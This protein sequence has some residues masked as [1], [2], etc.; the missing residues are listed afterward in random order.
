M[1]VLLLGGDHILLVV[2]GGR[3]ELHWLSSVEVMDLRRGVVWSW[4][5]LTVPRHEAALAVVPGRALPDPRILQL[6]VV[7]GW[8]GRH[9]L[10]TVEC[11]SL[12]PLTWTNLILN[13]NNR[14][15]SINNSTPRAATTRAPSQQDAEDAEEEEEQNTLEITRV[16]CLMHDKEEK[17]LDPNH[18]KTT[19]PNGQIRRRRQQVDRLCHTLL[20]YY[21]YQKQ[22]GLNAATA[23]LSRHNNQKRDQTTSFQKP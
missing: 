9:E 5:D 20:F 6:W 11:L 3:R 2:A 12:V 21:L 19:V 17:F 14:N 4:P 13:N 22:H 23:L 7:G 16:K 1:T 8:N 15:N 18:Q 10:E